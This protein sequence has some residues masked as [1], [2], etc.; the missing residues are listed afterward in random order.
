M[1]NIMGT[2]ATVSVP[3][4]ESDNLAMYTAITRLAFEELNNSWSIYD[5]STTVSRLNAGAGEKWIELDPVT[6]KLLRHI[7]RYAERSGGAFDPTISPLVQAWGF[8]G[9]DVPLRPLTTQRVQP[10]LEACGYEHLV[11]SNGNAHLELKGMSVDPGGIAK[12]LAVDV[13]Y[14]KLIEQGGENF[15]VNLGGNLRCMGVARGD[16][17]W[18]IGVQN[19]FD[20]G[21]IVGSLEVTDGWATATSGNYERF[22]QIDGKYYAHI[23]DPRSGMPVEGIAGVTVLSRSAVEADALSTAFFVLG[24]DGTRKALKRFPKSHVLLIEDKQPLQIW[25]SP[26]FRERFKPSDAYADA[27]KDL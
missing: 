12:G 15:M 14:G 9:G 21:D 2:F 22:I 13:A 11:V 10:L 23:I 5:S 27:I 1:W 25:V 17:P 6:E 18:V 26:G 16:S 4:A 19:P 3:A 8:S 24:I 7:Q 20:G